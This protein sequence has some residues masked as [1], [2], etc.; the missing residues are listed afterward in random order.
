MGHVARDC[1]KER[2][3]FADKGTDH[4]GNLLSNP[5]NRYVSKIFRVVKTIGD[6]DPDQRGADVFILDSRSIA[7]SIQP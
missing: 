6:K 4:L 1:K 7:V 3:W 5:V 2:S